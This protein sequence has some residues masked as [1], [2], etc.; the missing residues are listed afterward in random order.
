MPAS[1]WLLGLWLGQA[2]GVVAARPA[3][4]TELKVVVAAPVVRT[5]PSEAERL[6][7]STLVAGRALG[8]D[9]V[10][11]AVVDRGGSFDHF[12]LS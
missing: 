8:E 3:G 4:P 9:V 6:S 12:N 1:L 5:V 7:L 11:L 10:V 2:P